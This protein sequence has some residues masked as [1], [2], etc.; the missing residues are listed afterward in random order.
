MVITKDSIHAEP[1]T[2]QAPRRTSVRNKLAAGAAMVVLAAGVAIAVVQTT[3]STQSDQ[4]R[5]A[6]RS[7]DEL[8]SDLVD[9]GLVPA[10]SLDDGSQISG[11]ALKPSART[12]DDVVRD[13]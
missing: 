2:I 11:S 4:T 7:S 5:P 9:R 8:V 13:L 3:G 12:R 10:A 6:H 1:T